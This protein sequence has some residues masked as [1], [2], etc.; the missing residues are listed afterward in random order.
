MSVLKRDTSGQCSHRIFFVG[1]KGKSTHAAK[2]AVAHNN[3]ILQRLKEG[4]EHCE[5]LYEH[6]SFKTL[7]RPCANMGSSGFTWWMVT[8]ARIELDE[9]VHAMIGVL[10]WED[11]LRWNGGFNYF[12]NEIEVG[13]DVCY[14]TS[15]SDM[16]EVVLR[17]LLEVILAGYRRNL[18][19]PPVEEATPPPIPLA[20]EPTQESTK[21][22]LLNGELGGAIRVANRVRREHFTLAAAAVE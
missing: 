12:V 10:A 11:E 20:P 7:S 5:A 8:L 4:A 22:A 2:E 21:V 13:H 1:A 17:V 19:P 15:K 3:E 14:F 9:F 16:A 18:S 6:G